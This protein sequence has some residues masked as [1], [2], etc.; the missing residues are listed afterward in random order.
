MCHVGNDR[1][2]P[3][4]FLPCNFCSRS[5]VLNRSE[6]AFFACLCIV[7]CSNRCGK[8]GYGSS[9]LLSVGAALH[10]ITHSRLVHE[11]SRL[12]FK[13]RPGHVTVMDSWLVWSGL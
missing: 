3:N 7:E 13:T 2:R 12:G 5:A 1:S 4:N 9:S 10:C 6:L 11:A 8:S